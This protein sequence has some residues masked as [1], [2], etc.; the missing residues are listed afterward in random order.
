MIH[1]LESRFP[2]R[3]YHSMPGI[4]WCFMGL[5]INILSAV[6]T[7]IKIL[8][9]RT[10]KHQI[11]CTPQPRISQ[12]KPLSELWLT[13]EKS[14]NLQYFH[15]DILAQLYAIRDRRNEGNIGLKTKLSIYLQEQK[16]GIV[17]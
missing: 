2:Y 14:P 3:P 5:V 17:L 12:N 1:T 4:R 10:D 9:R 8:E 7:F 11:G 15:T 6:I 13:S 16:E